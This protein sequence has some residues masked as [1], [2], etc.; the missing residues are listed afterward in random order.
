MSGQPNPEFLRRAIALATQNVT[1][2][3][4]G[5]FGAVIVRDGRIIGEGVNSVT[6]TNDPTAHAEV[7]AIRAAATSLG[8]FTLEGC[9][10]YSSCEPCP[11]CLAA[12]YWARLGAVYYGANAADAARAGFDDSFIYTELRKNAGQRQLRATQM[13]GDEAW[14]SFAAWIASPNKVEY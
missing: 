11:M 6:A 10:L 4:G 14:A 8:T 7:N 2:G 13:L 3:R 5:P 12:A 1:A 9:E